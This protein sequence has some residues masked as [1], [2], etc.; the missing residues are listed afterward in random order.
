MKRLSIDARSMA[1]LPLLLG[2][3]SCSPRVQGGGASTVAPSPPAPA[4]GVELEAPGAQG[5]SDALLR[6]GISALMPTGLTT[7]GATTLGNSVYV[8]GGYSGTP[9]EYSERDQSRDFLRLDLSSGRWEKLPA[10]SPIQ[11]VGLASDERYVYRV[12]GMHARNQPG[13]P[14]EMHSVAEVARFDPKT[15]AWHAMTSLPVPRS[16]HAV[17]IANGRLYV[18]GGWKLAGGSFDAEWQET[19]MSCDLTQPECVW[20]SQPMPFATRAH[21]AAVHEGKLYVLGGLTPKGSTDDV[22]VYDL[23]TGIWSKGPSLP[24]DNLTICA[25]T[26]RDRLYANG[27]DGA[28]YALSPDGA[29]W[30]PAA[31]LTFPRMFHQLVSTPQGLLA[32]GG[33]PSRHRGARIRH[34][35][36]ISVDEPP[37]AVAWTLEAPSPA[38]NRQ[39]AFL[40][41]QQLIVFGGNNSLEQHDFER[42][43]FVAAAHRLDLGSLSWKA[44]ESFPFQRQSMQTLMA[45]TA[46]KPLGLVVGGFGFRGEL[47]GSQPDVASYDFA[48]GKWAT[49]GAG[50]PESRS[51]F[52]LIEW[53]KSAWIIGGLNFEAERKDDE[54]RHPT[55]VLRLD[56]ERPEAGFVD[57]GFELREMRRAFAGARLGDRY[58]MTGGL[59]QGFESVTTC[60]VLDLKTKTTSAMACPSRHRLGGEL[61]ALGGKLYLIGGSVQNEQGQRE[62]TT[63][64]ESYDPGK[65]AWSTLSETLPLEAPKQL[66]AFAYGDQLL[67]YTAN[68]PSPAV[69][70]ALLNPALL[71]SSPPRFVNIVAR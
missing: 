65:D 28:L 58:F 40:H 44:V 32:L 15:G 33:I 4:T 31:S 69:Q 45:G 14:E 41:G 71:G 38:K 12:G 22:Q 18:V 27:A 67:L 64:I 46:E 57:A 48:S 23:S 47:L 1:A 49:L 20:Q 37:A 9:H 35:E 2:I 17:A 3:W 30:E 7:L 16:S 56:L 42:D 63:R 34:V 29:R 6:A 50:L 54:F 36:R 13:Q 61:V 19:L 55:G 24:N 5:S 51:Q 52:G 25:A 60:E 26:Y 10:V 53:E 68:F 66:R 8:L 11:S 43:N 70:V 39:G 62:P 59:K 21:G